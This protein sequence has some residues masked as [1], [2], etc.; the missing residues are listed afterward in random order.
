MRLGD[1]VGVRPVVADPDDGGVLGVGEPKVRLELVASTALRA[2]RWRPRRRWSDPEACG[3]RR[4]G[5]SGASPRS[6]ACV[7]EARSDGVVI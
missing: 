2:I 7:H 5:A 4:L 3:R 6:A 1:A